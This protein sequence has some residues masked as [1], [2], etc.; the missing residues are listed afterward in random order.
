MYS[1]TLRVGADVRLDE[2]VFLSQGYRATQLLLGILSMILSSG[3]RVRCFAVVILPH[4]VL[5]VCR[6][7][8]TIGIGRV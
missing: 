5:P 1:P 8:L 4:V 2:L 3:L 6:E 7:S